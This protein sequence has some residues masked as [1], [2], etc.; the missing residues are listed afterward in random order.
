MHL[1]AFHIQEWPKSDIGM[2]FVYLH[3]CGTISLIH[4][5]VLI[6]LFSM[7]VSFG[8]KQLW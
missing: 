1:K 3:E 7:N 2:N 5:I 6:L 4:Q 8:Q